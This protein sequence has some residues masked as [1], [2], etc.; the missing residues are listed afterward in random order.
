MTG[1]AET[2]DVTTAATANRPFNDVAYDND[3]SRLDAIAK[4]TGRAKFPSDQT[5][6]APLV[7]AFV[8][9][10]WGHAKL[11]SADA[12]AA[13]AVKGVVEVSVSV[14]SERRYHG[15]TA[16]YVV[17]ENVHALRRGLSALNCQ[18]ERLDAVVG[19]DDAEPGMPDDQAILA[20]LHD[21]AHVVSTIY[22]TQVQT[23]SCMETHG[24]WVS[25]LGDRAVAYVSTQSNF[26]SR[27]ELARALDLPRGDVEMHCEYVGGGFGSK[28]GAG[29]EGHLAARTSKKYKRPCMVFCDRESDQLDTGNRPSSRQHVTVGVSKDGR[30]IGGRRVTY[31]GVGVAGGGGGVRPTGY[32][33]GNLKRKHTDVSFNAGGPR[34]FRAPGSPQGQFAMELLMDEL[35]AGIDMDPL[36]LRLKNETSPHRPAMYEHGA[37]LIGWADRTPNGAQPGPV[38]IGLGMG[39]T[40]WG[41]GKT[42]C[43]AEVVI[44]PDGSVESR[45]GTQDI[46]TGQRTVVGVTAAHA[47]GIPLAWVRAR[48]GTTDLPPGPASGG[49]VT[50][51]VSAPAITEAAR[52]ARLELL[53]GVAVELDTQPDTLDIKDGRILRDGKPVMDWRDACRLI[54]GRVSGRARFPKEADR[55]WGKG[56]CEGV[57]FAKVAVDCTTGVVRV[58][59][60]V[61]IQSCGQT[62]C[63]KTAESQIMGAVIQ[64]LSYALLE[65]RL[66]DRR[67]G[68]MVNPNFETYKIAGA[69]DTPKIVPVLWPDGATGARSLGEPPTIPT[70][71]AIA[72]AIYNAIGVPVRSLPMMPDKVLAALK[73]VAS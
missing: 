68:A 29:K 16:G 72:C 7:A 53:R 57:Q 27:D 25:V 40:N 10:P 69:M 44:H 49:S 56:H 35:A 39:V 4:V 11:V 63:R 37:T 70:S 65:D 43:E 64:G 14:G 73:G 32:T 18:W 47:I 2:I 28:F 12:D 36:R 13:K 59:T 20:T 3:T 54:R 52:R 38:K 15:H 58:L 34:A 9:C 61:A 30:I 31:G 5:A 23:H 55:H 71:G 24:G 60:I 8:R 45:S 46:G 48:V 26:G 50:T 51:R 67:T 41:N 66:L 33:M 62:I 42:N 6:G 21:A 17:A 22:R 19:I 1:R